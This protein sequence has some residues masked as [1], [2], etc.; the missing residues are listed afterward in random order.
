MV[1][2]STGKGKPDVKCNQ[3]FVGK[4]GRLA[5]T[6]TATLSVGNKKGSRACTWG[7]AACWS[8]REG[9]GMGSRQAKLVRRLEA[10]HKDDTSFRMRPCISARRTLSAFAVHVQADMVSI[11]SE[12]SRYRAWLT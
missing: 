1:A 12:F 10:A 7:G 9:A 11:T 2:C 5:Y 4:S 3:N 8:A 6:G